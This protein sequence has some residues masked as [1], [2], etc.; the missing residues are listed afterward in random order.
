MS[1]Q[2]DNTGASWSEKDESD[3]SPVYGRN[4]DEGQEAHQHLP[5]HVVDHL[6]AAFAHKAG[7][8][9]HP[10]KLAD[11]KKKARKHPGLPGMP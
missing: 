7:L 10:G 2:S 3:L 5:D 6:M 11:R 4:D 1:D 9:P 8:G